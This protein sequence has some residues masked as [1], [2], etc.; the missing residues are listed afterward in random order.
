MCTVWHLSH[1]KIKIDASR[2]P[3]IHFLARSL[4]WNHQFNN[5][6]WAS[7]ER[8]AVTSP[9]P[10]SPFTPCYHLFLLHCKPPKDLGLYSL[11]FHTLL[12]S[13]FTS[14]QSSQR[15][16]TLLKGSQGRLNFPDHVWT[17]VR[18][19]TCALVVNSL[20]FTI[21]IPGLKIKLFFSCKIVF[22]TTYF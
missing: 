7:I 11:Y 5:A 10:S 6:L 19:T 2:E 18:G 20:Q 15:P 21:S 1:F 9:S 17:H 13:V 22:V 4:S 16:W 8:S 3:T 12:S 14:L